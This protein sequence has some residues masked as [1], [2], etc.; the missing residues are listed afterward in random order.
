[1]DTNKYLQEL[2]S[3]LCAPSRRQNIELTREWASTFP[4]EPGNYIITENGQIIYAGET[5]SLKGRML[6]L[7]DTRNHCVRR[8]LGEKYYQDEL[9]YRKATSSQTFSDNI[10]ELINRHMI[11]RLRV[12]TLVVKLGRKELE[13]LIQSEIAQE[14]KLNKRGAR[15]KKNKVIVLDSILMVEPLNK[16]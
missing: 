15:G 8:S 7:L 10:E 2:K 4:D 11:E 16:N 6:D 1:M 13:E 9:D 3:K 5:G 12:S 14:H